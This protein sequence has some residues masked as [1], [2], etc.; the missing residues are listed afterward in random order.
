MSRCVIH[1]FHYI[2]K[3]LSPYL[4][5]IIN[6]NLNHKIVTT[7]RSLSFDDFNDALSTKQFAVDML[8]CLKLQ[9]KIKRMYVEDI[10][11]SKEVLHHKT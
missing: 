2:I 7:S 5:I 11:E 8:S 6:V 9:D 10:G 1:C 3:I 4:P